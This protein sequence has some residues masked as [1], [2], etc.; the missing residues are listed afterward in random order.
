MNVKTISSKRRS[1]IHLILKSE[2][3]KITQ[4]APELLYRRFNVSLCAII[5][6]QIVMSCHGLP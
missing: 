4:R 1:E 6:V 3:V 5:F 2:H